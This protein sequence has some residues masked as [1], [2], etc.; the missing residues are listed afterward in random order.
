MCWTDMLHRPFSQ[1]S[2][3]NRR[4]LFFDHLCCSTFEQSQSLQRCQA[5]SPRQIH[6]VI[7][8]SYSTRSFEWST[9]FSPCKIIKKNPP[10]FL[11]LGW[12]TLNQCFTMVNYTHLLC[13]DVKRK[14]SLQWKKHGH[15]NLSIKIK[16]MGVWDFGSWLGLTGARVECEEPG[17]ILYASLTMEA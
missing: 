8:S 15:M 6:S 1:V 11:N 2:E 7:F 14:K 9:H 5:N 3:I 13:L 17:V 16:T 12:L 4:T 10:Y